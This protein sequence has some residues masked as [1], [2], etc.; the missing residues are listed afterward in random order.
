MTMTTALGDA[1][2]AELR[3]AVAGADVVAAVRFALRAAPS[4]RPT[5]HRRT[6][7]SRRSGAATTRTMS[8]GSTRTSLPHP[9]TNQ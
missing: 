1:T 3:S 2:V 7:D 4:E 8:S 9:R 6:L 5:H